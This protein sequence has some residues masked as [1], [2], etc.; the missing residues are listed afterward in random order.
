[1]CRLPVVSC[2]C[3]V[4]RWLMEKEVIYFIVPSSVCVCECQ[5]VYAT[6]K[7]LHPQASQATILLTEVTL[8]LLNQSKASVTAGEESLTHSLS[9]CVHLCARL[10]FFS[11]L[12]LRGGLSMLSVAQINHHYSTWSIEMPAS[13]KKT[14][15]LFVCPSVCLLCL[16]FFF[17]SRRGERGKKENG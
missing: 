12:F 4:N 13:V 17:S 11:F 15:C 14:V 1:M 3:R 6:L 5:Q 7:Y 9:S 10:F 16:P 2:S 8:L